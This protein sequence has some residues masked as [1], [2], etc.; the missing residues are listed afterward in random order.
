MAFVKNL[1]DKNFIEYASYVIRDRAIPDLEDGLKPVQRRIMHTLFKMDDGRFQKVANVVGECMKYHPH[2]DASIGGAL[3]VLANKGIFIEKQGNFGNMY[4]GDGASAPRYIECRVHPLAKEFLVTNPAVT[5][6]IPNYDGRSTEPEVYRAKVPVALIIG[7]EGIAV[8]MSTKILP[9]NIRE[10]LEAEIKALNNEPFEIYP[11]LPTGGLIDVTNYNDGNGK[12]VTRAKFDMSDEKKIIITELPVDTTSESLMNSIENAYKAGR[13]KI[14][15]IDDYTTDHCQIEIKLPRGVYAKDIEKA[16]YAYTDC[17]KSISCQMLVIRDNMPVAMTAT[18]II[19]YYAKKLT[20]II[21]DE[22]EYD[23]GRLTEELHARTLERIFI[24]ERIYKKIEQMKTAEDVVKAVKK[25]FVPF[26]AELVRDISDEDVETLLKIPIRRISLFDINKNKDQVA[27][28]NK[29]L[30]EISRKLKHLKDCA[31]D[32]LEGMLKKFKEEELVRH[33]QIQ[34]FNV[35]DVKAVAKRDIPLRYDDKGYLGTGVSGGAE[36]L[37]VTPYDRIFI[38]RRSGIYT[39]CD[40]PQKLFVD[41][42]MWY[43]NL[44]EKDVISKVLFTVIYRD[45]KN[46]YCYIKKC[47]IPSWI[48]NRDYLMAP[49]GME[50]LHVDTR[51]KFTFTLKY[52]KKPRVKIL[53]EDFDSANFEE[54]GHKAQGVRLSD[55]DT[56]SISVQSADAQIGLFEGSK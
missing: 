22:L 11:D 2:G 9:Y 46:G 1:F 35:V 4:T 34:K 42:G 51:E 33:T 38:L 39:V 7:A 36:V 56:E 17:E 5:H 28:I 31:V 3:V 53:S 50:V 6:Y 8:G 55:H 16:L 18:E 21:K 14:S 27:A 30:K 44:A 25:G 32:Y 52:K 13:I 43:C 40:V 37:R 23:Q 54:K 29:Q 48:M 12:I 41:T 10:V 20:A 24:E 19:K 15:S 26:K 47:R 45:P 49:D